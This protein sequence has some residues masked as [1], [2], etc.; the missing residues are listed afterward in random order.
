MLL[1]SLFITFK[2]SI[3]HL[4]VNSIFFHFFKRIIF[5]TIYIALNDNGFSIIEPMHAT[6]IRFSKKIMFENEF[7]RSKKKKKE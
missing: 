7:K 3:W 5:D 1:K 4:S 6:E 2:H